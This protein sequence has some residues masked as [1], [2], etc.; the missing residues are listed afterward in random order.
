MSS[1]TSYNNLSKIGRVTDKNTQ[2]Y[3]EITDLPEDKIGTNSLGNSFICPC[4][5][6]KLHKEI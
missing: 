3:Q 6:I 4:I 2:V 5:P 1:R